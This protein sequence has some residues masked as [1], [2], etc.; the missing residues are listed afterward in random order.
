MRDGDFLAV[1]AETEHEAEAA[2]ARLGACLGARLAW[3]ERDTLPD[4]A[5]M[6]EWL[7]AASQKET[8]II[9]RGEAPPARGV[10]A[11]FFRPPV[12]HASI[13]PSCAIARWEQGRVEVWSHTQGPYNLRTDM[14]LALRI[15]EEA[16]TIR[17]VEGAGCYG[18][19]GADDMALDAALAARAVPGRPVRVLWS[20]ADELAWPPV[21]SAM[22]V[23][24]EA[25]LDEAGNIGA[26]R[27]EVTSN[28]HSSRP[29]RG[30]LP[31]LLA[32]AHLAEPFAVPPA[33][34]VS[35][36]RGGGAQR[37][38]VPIDRVPALRVRMRTVT[39]MPLRAS[40]MRRLGAPL[41]VWAIESVM[42]E[43]AALAGADPLH[44]RLRHL[45]DPRAAAV[46]REAAA[47]AGWEGRTRRGGLGWAWRWRA[48]R[49]WAGGARS[50][51]R[52]RRK[53]SCAPGGSGSPPTWGR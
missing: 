39:E 37:N 31:T 23:E 18:H 5:A 8:V 10:A 34:N 20:R 36:E 17:H 14:A 38:A 53:R 52:W 27:L 22:L 40:A 51:P 48:T 7:H 1:L 44:F 26:F 15:P 50:S 12:A 21:S 4:E 13:G 47:M 25:A 19:N 43:L 46:L 11:R 30:K 28:G 32:A 3:E 16:V 35:A 45:D 49:T 9:A 42:D 41:N 24:V 2:A 33:I 6:A 29:G